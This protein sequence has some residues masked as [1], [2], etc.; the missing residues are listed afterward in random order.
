[1]PRT[2]LC[3]R[4][5]WISLK[6]LALP[7][8][9]VGRNTTDAG[10]RSVRFFL[11]CCNLSEKVQM[12]TQ[13]AR[14]GGHN[15]QTLLPIPRVRHPKNLASL[16]RTNALWADEGAC[17]AMVAVFRPLLHLAPRALASIA[18]V[19]QDAWV[20]W[21]FASST[22]LSDDSESPL[23]RKEKPLKRLIM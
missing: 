12:N 11:A 5:T 1:M 18:L 23:L 6:V 9:T 17:Q 20:K 2:A 4:N 13:P 19:R 10:T 14:N 3:G 22:K 21:E 7:L 15:A 8:R 16:S